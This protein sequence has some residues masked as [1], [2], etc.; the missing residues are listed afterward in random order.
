MMGSR[1]RFRDFALVLGAVAFALVASGCAATKQARKTE[2]SGFLG[3]YSDLREGKDGQALLVYVDESADWK[4]YDKVLMEPITLWYD[5]A[6]ESKLPAKDEAQVLLDY[7]DESVR[8]A[9]KADYLFVDKPGPGVLRL[10]I[11][12]TEAR[13][14]NAVLDTVSSVVPQLRVLSGAKELAT[15][16]AAFV[17]TAG[18]EA[19]IEDSLTERRLAAGVDRRVGGKNIGGVTDS[20]NDVQK[21]FDFWSERLRTRLAELR[22]ATAASAE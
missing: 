7:L 12:L 10:R 1:R 16:T 19:E 11:A 18:V 13:A 14:S 17:G 3:D 9:L 2:T 5:P 6:D 15:G 8:N 20:W 22:G 4:Q 21:S